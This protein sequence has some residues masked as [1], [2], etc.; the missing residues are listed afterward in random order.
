[1]T[2]T[3]EQR[4]YEYLIQNGNTNATN[5]MNMAKLG[6]WAAGQNINT[7]IKLSTFIRRF[8]QVFALIDN[9]KLIYAIP[10]NDDDDNNK[11][12]EEGSLLS[13]SFPYTW[14]PFDFQSSTYAPHRP[15]DV[16][17]AARP[18]PRPSPQ[19]PPIT[20]EYNRGMGSPF[21]SNAVLKEGGKS[22]SKS[23]SAR[24]SKTARKSK[25]ARKS[26]SRKN[27]NRRNKTARH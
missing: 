12:Q 8:P 3:A 20:T 7:G 10:L 26:R 27:R 17:V 9:N 5:A 15:V 21:F 13:D 18:Q 6:L 22:K 23:R 24:K 16:N 4:I 25:S 11:T 1:M 14:S 19:S 2:A